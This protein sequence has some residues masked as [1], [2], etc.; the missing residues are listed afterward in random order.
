MKPITALM[1]ALIA[2]TTTAVLAANPHYKRGGQPVC[3]INTVTGAATC[4]TGEV[5]GLGN[6]DVLI[7]VTVTGSAGTF[8]HN[9]GN[10]N[11]VPGQNPAEGS[12]T[13][14]Q[15]IDADEIKNGTLVIDAISTGPVTFTA[16]SSEE[17]GCPNP[18]WSVTVDTANVE[19]SGFYSF[20]QPPGNQINRLSFAF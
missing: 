15:L 7:V 6:A 11:I 3:T 13:G 9:P 4:S 18:G 8:C 20:Q 1:A 10:N 14:T 16:P 19:F 17:A 2:T 5:A 12:S